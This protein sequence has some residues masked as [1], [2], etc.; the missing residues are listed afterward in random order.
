MPHAHDFVSA[1][2]TPANALSDT[3]P[4][5]EWKRQIK[6]R[7]NTNLQKLYQDAD[8]LY[9]R[10]L[11]DVR[12]DEER[13]HLK[14]DYKLEIGRIR[15]LGAEEYH[16]QLELERQQRKW[17]MGQP[18]DAKW[19]DALEREHRKIFE[20]Y[21]PSGSGSDSLPPNGT[22]SGGG[23]SSSRSN[24]ATAQRTTTVPEYNL[25]PLPPEIERRKASQSRE[26]ERPPPRVRRESD[27]VS[28]SAKEEYR[29]AAYFPSTEDRYYEPRARSGTEEPE[30]SMYHSLNK[31]RAS[32]ERSPGVD[33][34]EEDRPSTRASE[35]LTRS[36]TERYTPTS[37]A[38]HEIWRPS[39]NAEEEP[40]SS[41][42]GLARRGSSA[43]QR[44][45][46]STSIRSLTT[47][48]IPERPDGDGS[49]GITRKGEGEK[50]D[51]SFDK[52]K[53]RQSQSRTFQMATEQGE[54]RWE[55]LPVPMMG[56]S[57]QSNSATATATP[58][59]LSSD[60]T[61]STYPH[62]PPQRS[63]SVKLPPP[64]LPPPAHDDDRVFPLPAYKSPRRH[65]SKSSF[66][67]ESI[68]MR[69][70]GAS[71]SSVLD[72]PATRERD[73]LY[74]SSSTV[75][76]HRPLVQK[77][78]FARMEQDEDGRYGPDWYSAPGRRP[79]MTSISSRDYPVLDEWT[80]HRF[81][82]RSFAP[83]NPFAD[84]SYIG[85]RRL[86]SPERVRPSLARGASFSSNRSVDDYDVGGY[87]EAYQRSHIQPS[88]SSS[89][90]INRG[91]QSRSSADDYAIP[92]WH[93]WTKHSEGRPPRPSPETRA[94]YEIYSP[95]SSFNAEPGSSSFPTRPHNFGGRETNDHRRNDHVPDS[96]VERM[97]QRYDELTEEAAKIEE[98]E[99]IVREKIEEARR[100]EEEAKRKQEE[101]KKLGD[102]AKR[103]KEEARRLEEE[104]KRKEEETR[105]KEEEVKRKEEETRRKE[106]EIRL[107]EEDARLREQ[108]A[109]LKQE[110]A[111]LKEEEVRLKEEDARIKEE[112]AIRKEEETRR[113]EDEI[114]KKEQDARRKEREVHKKEQEAKRK[115][116]EA[117]RLEE[118]ARRRDEEARRREEETE[119]RE[120]EIERREEDIRK[121]EEE[122]KRREEELLRRETESRYEEKL[123][124]MEEEA[125]REREEE[126][127]QE[128]EAVRRREEAKREEAA[129]QEEERRYRLEED[130]KKREEEK[131]RRDED[132][133]QRLEAEL[134]ALVEERLRLE[135]EKRRR[136]EE[137]HRIEEERKRREEEAERRQ[138]EENRRKEQEEAAKRQQE[139]EKRRRQEEEW[140]KEQERIHEEVMRREWE[141]RRNENVQN[142][143]HTAQQGAYEKQRE[144]ILKRKGEER[145]H[146]PSGFSSDSGFTSS[147]PTGN[148]SP[149]SSS[150]PPNTP[151]RQAS[152][153]ASAWT[154]ATGSA[155]K[156]ASSATSTTSPPSSTPSSARTST[157]SSSTSATSASSSTPTP[158][159]T[160]MP[161][162]TPKPRGAAA[163]AASSSSPSGAASS[164]APPLSENEWARR[165]AEQAKEQQ[166][167]FRR[168]QEKLENQRIAKE[169]NKMITEKDLMQLYQMH[170]ARWKD[171]NTFEVLRWDAFPW[172]LVRRPKTAEDIKELAIQ[173][174]L[175]S[176]A[177]PE[178]DYKLDKDRVKEHIK[179]WHPDKFNTKYLPKVIE[180]DKERV[181][182]GA[183]AVVR[184]LNAILTRMNEPQHSS[185]FG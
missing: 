47:E 92:S 134:K 25:P 133:Q 60:R 72:E 149:L 98:A 90:P 130:K 13:V 150:R 38:R 2:P 118:D 49:G 185:L 93:E 24:N 4:P 16:T 103:R 161:A 74:R 115:E 33:R 97:R 30:G 44:S 55:E 79:P 19:K 128:E 157:S 138:E 162:S 142:N 56:N 37:P 172:P 52:G 75:H 168:E 64:P 114:K 12:S 124:L 131:R 15:A 107:K 177:H 137:R 109:K 183:G 91:K 82:E 51:S 29:H 108:E 173:A 175:F 18:I 125:E 160:P 43:S 85:Y 112:E 39:A 171:L 86:Q 176:R 41:R 145:K 178:R 32:V 120:E 34:S 8:E 14:E 116:L 135:E 88:L 110:E 111:R 95:P 1:S 151:Q 182:E 87:G 105:R 181:K 50:V 117:K 21:K 164:S 165:Q 155:W 40:T 141:R 5:D 67:A 69:H 71:A 159:P 152:M 96:E 76:G 68:D 10:R 58:G 31:S 122:L 166:E 123:R 184:G 61:P 126:R 42:R 6:E 63:S 136:D 80:G 167:R 113:K 17:A 129:R 99:K 26:G 100:K 59:R 84:D 9:K 66:T 70:M 78:S 94:S 81:R 147:S 106:E 77:P 132:R 148:G 140:R 156:T 11:H 154:S 73:Y 27:A 54:Q 144:E 146:Q 119:R 46:G 7:I 101:A 127:R 48:P 121:R 174:Y 65:A 36:G 53:E 45:V 139:E 28:S 153:S 62:A 170:E 22:Q 83:Y 163:A 179:R 35:R 180:E 143:V 57:K 102:E 89:I 3:E 20:S 169:V 23:G 158:T 104:L